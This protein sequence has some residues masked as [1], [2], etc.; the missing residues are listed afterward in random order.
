[1]EITM[2]TYDQ[3]HVLGESKKKQ[4][5]FPKQYKTSFQITRLFDKT[6]LTHITVLMALKRGKALYVSLKS[7]YIQHSSD[8]QN[9]AKGLL[10]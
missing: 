2:E 5:K 3:M 10:K 6:S 4:C 9:Y 1:M 8:V 7:N